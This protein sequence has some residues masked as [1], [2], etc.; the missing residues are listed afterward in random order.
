MEFDPVQVDPLDTNGA[1]PVKIKKGTLVV[2]HNAVV[3][4]SNENTSEHSR[5]AYSIHVVDGKKGITY[6]ADNW[7]QRPEGYPFR[8]I[9]KRAD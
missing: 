2:L 5:H 4:Y 7:L 9:L 8:E 1:I 6:P 3:H